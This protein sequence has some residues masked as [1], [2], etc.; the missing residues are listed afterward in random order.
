M[1]MIIAPNSCSYKGKKEKGEVKGKYGGV[2]G[3]MEGNADCEEW[4]NPVMMNILKKNH[5]LLLHIY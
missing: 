3:E 1:M 2:C 5:G 4:C